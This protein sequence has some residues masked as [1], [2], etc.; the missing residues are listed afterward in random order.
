MRH[1]GTPR[2]VRRL[3]WYRDGARC[4]YCGRP[5]EFAEMTADHVVPHSR[6]GKTVLEN[7]VCCCKPCN[8]A[9]RDREYGDFMAEFG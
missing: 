2:N 1:H 4:H 7:L 5:V 9:K 8:S 6:G 3:V